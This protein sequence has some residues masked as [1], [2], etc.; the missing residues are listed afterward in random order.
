MGWFSD[1]FEVFGDA[2]VAGAEKPQRLIGF[3]G[4]VPIYSDQPSAVSVLINNTPEDE[5]K[6]NDEDRSDDHR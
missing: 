5:D 6:E 4:A 2:L 3:A 1:V